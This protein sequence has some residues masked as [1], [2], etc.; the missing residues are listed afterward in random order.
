MSTTK[1]RSLKGV[2][3]YFTRSISVLRSVVII[4]WSHAALVTLDSFVAQL[5]ILLVTMQTVTIHNSCSFNVSLVNF[6]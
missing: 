2:V 1:K 5:Q 3:E 6:G 4:Y